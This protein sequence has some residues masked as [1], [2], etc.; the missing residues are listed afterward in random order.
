MRDLPFSEELHHVLHDK[1]A[2]E[3]LFKD[4]VIASLITFVSL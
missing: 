2:I 3:M 1:L 4:D